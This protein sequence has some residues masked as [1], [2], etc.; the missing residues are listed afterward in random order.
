VS[1][2]VGEIELEGSVLVIRRIHVRLKLK[3]EEP[4]RETASKVHGFFAEKCPVYLSLYKAITMT[5]EL[6]FEPLAST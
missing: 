6:L 4:N 5:T 2:A 1:E 3:A